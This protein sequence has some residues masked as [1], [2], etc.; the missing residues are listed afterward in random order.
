MLEA[1]PYITWR[2]VQQVLAATAEKND[3]SDPDWTTNGAG[4]P[5][6]H[7][8]GFGRIDA[9]AAVTAA[10]SWT[11]S[12]P[13]IST[14]GDSDPNLPIPDDDATGVS[15]TI[16]IADDIS[17]ENVEIFFSATDH[18][19]WGDLQIELTSPAGT[20]SILSEMHAIATASGYDNWRFGSVRHLGESSQGTWTLTVKDLWAV[21]TGTFQSW[22]L[23]IWG[24]VVPCF[25]G[26]FDYDCDVDCA[27]FT[28]LASA[29]M[30]DPN[31]ANWNPVCDISGPS[32]NII[33]INDLAVSIANWLA[34]K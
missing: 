34:G 4:F 5:V 2:D 18:T 20:T 3:P 9:A 15:D 10:G 8:Y 31:D 22:T 11:N 21:D 17:I 12:G 29:W 7:K 33:D 1:N 13:E 28:V 32:G 23:K 24:S 6:N 16:A 27:D 30:A 26:D 25:P 19:Y 14:Q